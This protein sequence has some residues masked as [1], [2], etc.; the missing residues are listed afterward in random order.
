MSQIDL[1]LLPLIRQDGQ[2]PSTFPGIFMVTPPK[3]TARGR[4]DDRLVLY[5]TEQGNS[6][7]GEEQT[8]RILAK[9]SQSYYKASGSVTAAL[10]LTADAMN[11]FLL[12]LN[13]KSSSSGRQCIGLLALVV[14]RDQRLTAGVCG[15]LRGWLIN[16]QAAEEWFDPQASGRGLGLA[17][18][19]SIRFFQ[20]E[21]TPNSYLIL[22]AQP[23]V[24]WTASSLQNSHSQG[25]ESF[26]RRLLSNAGE[27]L[28][29]IV[30]QLQA[31]MG[32]V[33][34]LRVRPP[35][36]M[37]K[38][39]GTSAAA[40]PDKGAGV[41]EAKETSEPAAPI[42]PPAPVEMPVTIASALAQEEPVTTPPSTTQVEVPSEKT[43]TETP[44]PDAVPAAENTGAPA[45]PSI[46]PGKPVRKSSQTAPAAIR[47]EPKPAK[48]PRQLP[49]IDFAPVGRVFAPIGKAI[50]TA[51]AGVGHFLGSLM[52]KILP[53]ESLFSLPGATMAFIA[54]A[55]AVIMATAGIY[56][57]WQK[58]RAA[59]YQKYFDLALQ[60]AGA[61]MTQTDPDERRISWETSLDYVGKAED[62]M[63]TQ[64]SQDLRVNIL[65]QL[66]VMDAIVRLDYKPALEGFL[67]EDVVITKIIASGTNLF[68]LN[69]NTGGVIRAELTG[70]G[71]ELDP[72]FDCNPNP[73]V[74]KILD[75]ILMPA[76]LSLSSE[77]TLLGLDDRNQLVYCT[78]DEAPTTNSPA[79]PYLG[80]ATPNALALEDGTLYILDPGTSSIWYYE[81]MAINAD[82]HQYFD[83]QVP[84]KINTA[85]RLLVV[86]SRL[87]LLFADS[88]VAQC[89]TTF[90]VEDIITTCTDP[91]LYEDDREGRENTGIILDAHFN[92]LLYMPPPNPSL[93]M[94]DPIHQ[95]IYHFSQQL[96]LQRQY[97]P[98]NQISDREATAFA[99]TPNRDILLA[100][101][102]RLYIAPLP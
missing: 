20:T 59:E 26:R 81:E 31:G 54:I 18:A 69:S 53:D 10:R 60:H 93:Y 11:Q 52:K 70:K 96:A 45:H 64:D 13:L 30:V 46:T 14:L 98:L 90:G 38:Q 7:L 85:I 57:Y 74:G 102:N 12:D 16:P 86:D 75:M 71:Y 29:A 27:D 55:I 99:I 97:R 80:W 47:P 3:R 94:L 49:K 56:V 101:G 19:V 89:T 58:G 21:F 88:H 72:Y 48:A 5:F 73:L 40:E 25:I 83:E 32:K 78:P 4:E 68:L 33:R 6:P 23:P 2:E 84:S 39:G 22:S 91:L 8:S 77:F 17:R 61:A 63:L 15:P 9:L 43:R 24:T 42:I 44:L 66:D 51:L 34:L 79:A 36:Q 37:V 92:Q 87:Y 67:A 100:I 65:N 82:P 28:S 76:N 62:L 1:N 50:G 35:A 41:G 95:S